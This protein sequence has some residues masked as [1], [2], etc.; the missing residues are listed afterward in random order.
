MNGSGTNIYKRILSS[1]EKFAFYGNYNQIDASKISKV[2]IAGSPTDAGEGDVVSIPDI[3]HPESG[4][5]IT[6]HATLVKFEA[7]N[8][9]SST[10]NLIVNNVS[11]VG[12]GARSSSAY[13]SGGLIFTKIKGVNSVVERTS[14]YDF[15]IGC[16]MSKGRFM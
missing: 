10:P 11:L 1:N 5:A 13:N 2:V 7:V 8:S 15:L 9:N 6:S 12:N 3:S 4:T 14:F 16:M